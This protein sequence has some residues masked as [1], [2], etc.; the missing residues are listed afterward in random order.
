M[1]G[2]QKRKAFILI[3]ATSSTKLICFPAKYQQSVKI[4]EYKNPSKDTS[5]PSR[6][7]YRSSMSESSL[8]VIVLPSLVYPYFELDIE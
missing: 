6:D 1:T 7:P 3:T 2:V 4:A 8:R 5:R